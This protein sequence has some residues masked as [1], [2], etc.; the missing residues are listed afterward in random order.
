[1]KNMN[2]L[3]FILSFLMAI[4]GLFMFFSFNEVSLLG[5]KMS[6]YSLNEVN[7]AFNK[8]KIKVK[9]QPDSSLLAKNN[10]SRS[11]L[12]EFPLLDEALVG[13][14]IDSLIQLNKLPIDESKIIES[15]YLINL[16]KDGKYPLDAFFKRLETSNIGAIPLRV[17]HY[18]D[19]QI[20]GDRVTNL[21]RQLFQKKFGGSGNGYIPMDDVTQPVGYI[22]KNTGSW[23]RHTVFK[24]T[25]SNNYYGPGG[26]TYTYSADSNAATVSI[27]FFN[28]YNNLKIAYGKGYDNSTVKVFDQNS[29]KLLAEVSLNGTE[30]FQTQNLVKDAYCSR[31]LLT[32][33][34]K[35]PYIYGLYADSQSG[36]QLDNY[37]MRGQSG[38]G[39]V[40]ISLEQLKSIFKQQNNALSMLQFGGNVIPMVKN[41]KV[42]NTCG[43]SYKALYLHFKQALTDGSVLVLGVND[44]SRS[45]GGVY[46]SYD[47]I[48]ELRYLQRKYAVENGLAFFDLYQF[49]G[50]NESIGL[51]SQ[52]NLASKDG[53]L[54][55]EGRIILANELYK[56]L[57]FEYS[58][59]L[60]RKK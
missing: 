28:A 6:F 13:N 2:P 53:H 54:S 21:L 24:N 7:E 57:M 17:G 33:T 56:A 32:F 9:L 41:E 23:Q 15:P 19:S 1:M 5:H 40:R 49:M 37:G 35:S 8:K 46:K 47:N 29:R 38:D 48:S 42:L 34:G 11:K 14:Y 4:M 12:I 20:E 39:L 55:E 52:K 30:Y 51:W 50:G 16:P 18:G 58:Q 45:V 10:A 3:V 44:L 43:D 59:Y 31:I 27:Q 60:K 25:L 22:R 36:I 26:S